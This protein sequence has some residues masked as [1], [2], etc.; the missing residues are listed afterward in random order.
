MLL[1][2][3]KPANPKQ[4][5]CSA[6]IRRSKGCSAFFIQKSGTNE[7]S[8][9]RHVPEYLNLSRSAEITQNVMLCANSH[10]WTSFCD[11]ILATNLPH[12]GEVRRSCCI[13]VHSLAVL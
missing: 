8:M 12:F 6:V 5:A 2:T 7:L 11:M 1:F 9:L 10:V 3:R 13:A 4:H